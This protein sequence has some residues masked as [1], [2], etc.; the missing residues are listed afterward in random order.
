MMSRAAPQANDCGL[1]GAIGAKIF[2]A[3]NDPFEIR[4]L[5]P[6]LMDLQSFAL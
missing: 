2:K 5:G 1:L 4:S 6:L 3:E